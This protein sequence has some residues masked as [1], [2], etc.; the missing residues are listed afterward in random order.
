M[1]SRPE[2]SSD[3]PFGS[4]RDSGRD[5]KSN[6]VSSMATR[7]RSQ[8]LTTRWLSTHPCQAC[9]STTN[10]STT[11]LL[12]N[13]V[14]SLTS[15]HTLAPLAYLCCWK[16][17]YST[18]KLKLVPLTLTRVWRNELCILSCSTANWDYAVPKSWD[19][20]LWG[21]PVTHAQSWP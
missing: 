15:T 13:S 3:P 12:R 8:L 6:V 5:T 4:G 9:Q 10:R 20:C 21:N 19:P 14:L 2:L 18:P 16:C 1:V 17:L 11:L 7:L